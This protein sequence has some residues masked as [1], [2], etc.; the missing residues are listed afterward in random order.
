MAG[1]LAAAIFVFILI[2]V[3]RSVVA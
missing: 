2:M 3:V 1:V